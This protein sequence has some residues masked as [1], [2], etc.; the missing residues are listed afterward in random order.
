MTFSDQVR[1][2][3]REKESQQ[4]KNFIE[5]VATGDKGLL[6]LEAP[7]GGGKTSFL[8]HN[9]YLF[10]QASVEVI[11]GQGLQMS[12]MTPGYI[13]S[14]L[15]K[16][17]MNPQ[18]WSQSMREHIQYYFED[19]I[20][21]FPHISLSRQQQYSKIQSTDTSFNLFALSRIA[22][23]LAKFFTLTAS[24]EKPKILILDDVQWADELSKQTLKTWLETEQKH[25]SFFGII[26]C[27][28]KENIEQLS[29]IKPELIKMKID[30]QPLTQN[31]V[32]EYLQKIDPIF[33]VKQAESL[34]QLTAGN[35]FALQFLTS[36]L[37][38]QKK[39]DLNQPLNSLTATIHDHFHRLSDLQ[40]KILLQIAVF[41]KHLEL[42]TLSQLV[43]L[44]AQDCER[45]LIQPEMSLLISITEDFKKVVSFNHDKIR[46]AL[47]DL[48]KLDDKKNLHQKIATFLEHEKNHDLFKLAYHYSQAQNTEKVL[49]FAELAA[50]EAFKIASYDLAIQNYLLLLEFNKSKSES[51]ALVLAQLG[52]AYLLIGQYNLA[53]K[54]FKEAILCAEHKLT[55]SECLGKL[56]EIEFKQG[57]IQQATGLTEEALSLLQFKVPK[58][59]F[60]LAFFLI[61]EI[62]IQT[63]HSIFNFK[64]NLPP[65]NKT[66]ALSARLFSRLAYCYWFG[67]GAL[68]C[69]WAHI[70]GFNITENYADSLEKAQ[71]YSEH[72]PVMT[73]IPWY[74][75]G[76][77]YAR[78]SL[79]IRE[80][81]NSRWGV[82]QSK[83]FIGTCL[84]ASGQF[85]E[86]EKICLEAYDTLSKE[87]DM[88]EANLAGWHI[89]FSLY[90]QGQLQK[91]IEQAQKIFQI[92]KEINDNQ[93][94]AICIGV[95]GKASNG[96]L[97]EISEIEKIEKLDLTDVHAFVE[98]AT[99]KALYFS[100]FKKF[101]EA[102][103]IMQQA[104]DKVNKQGLRQ[105]YVSTIWPWM[106]TIIRY[107][108][109]QSFLNQKDS[110]KAYNLYYKNICES[111]RKAYFYKN[112]LPHALREKAYYYYYTGKVSKAL[113]ILSKSIEEAR[114]QK[115]NYEF[116]TSA[117]LYNLW[118]KENPQLNMLKIDGVDSH[119]K[120]E[121]PVNKQKNN[122]EFQ[123]LDF[124][125]NEIAQIK[126]SRD[127]LEKL[128]LFA[129]ELFQKQVQIGVVEYFF[130]NATY[131]IIPLLESKPQTFKNLLT[132]F[133]KD[134][135]ENQKKYVVKQNQV[136]FVIYPV[137]QTTTFGY[138]Y[139][140]CKDHD[141]ISH[142][143]STFAIL[144]TLVRLVCLTIE[145]KQQNTQVQLLNEDL[146]LRVKQAL[147]LSE[148]KNSELVEAEK[149]ALKASQ[150]KSEF[151]A[152]MSHEIRTP[153]NGVMGTISLL[154]TTELQ[155][156]QKIYLQALEI[157]SENLYN[158]VNDILD[159]SKIESGHQVIQLGP[160][161]MIDVLKQCY[162][163]Y[164]ATAAKKG[165]EL[166]LN[167]KD[168]HEL[169]VYGDILRI[170]QV[171]SNLITNAI[172]FT[173]HGSVQI[174]VTSSMTATSVS[175]DVEVIDS[176][177]GIESSDFEKLFQKFSQLDGSTK[178][179]V[180]GT[181]LG[182]SICYQLIQLM[183][184]QI[185]V[186]SQKGEGSTF[187]F[188]LS[189]KKLNTE[190]LFDKTN[191][192][193][194]PQKSLENHSQSSSQDGLSSNQT[195]A[196]KNLKV[197]VDE[198]NTINQLIIRKILESL[199]CTVTMTENGEQFLQKI[200]SDSFDVA[201]LDCQMP[202]LDGFEAC[203]FIR[204]NQLKAPPIIALTAYAMDSDRQ[205]C[206]DA[207]MDDYLT[208]PVKVEDLKRTIE[209]W[210]QS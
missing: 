162:E 53:T 45:V 133:S 109:E 75:R 181:G 95:I 196:W 123:S 55:R 58:T 185:G 122:F 124:F 127:G 40:K 8:H 81:L 13:L 169:E 86:S 107:K 68:F 76:L 192:T 97:T 38:E 29:F 183:Q 46:E 189:L 51:R 30:L 171:L 35:P 147:T 89:A 187:W 168:L 91:A 164:K 158:I 134:L 60:L 100:R 119:E 28:R 57:H 67:K 5:K 138:L 132:L 176:G 139:I 32:L 16:Y 188:K 84:Y 157:S 145:Q 110:N 83:G 1:F 98:L 113:V 71:A 182:L 130:N 19:I 199:N 208:K 205:R 66:Q 93:S 9:S 184:G 179:K 146:E 161:L 27:C 77:S 6:L 4:L 104:I 131:E 125:L 140:V 142:L 36:N 90:R 195:L 186:R 105:E 102:L 210:L 54:A 153:L 135:L 52:E 82:G 65:I 59:K 126:N 170:R 143:N 207:G 42:Q 202:V 33:N 116:S 50:A 26:I 15:S 203:Q 156:E 197:L 14:G 72:S 88:W 121:T 144:E 201:F 92:S 99:A 173:D 167:T 11:T 49:V 101:D 128:F 7:S 149:K 3:G 39:E 48:I 73:I 148:K 61:K 23:C 24:V 25:T 114:R 151:L 206:F 106:A 178:K 85:F 115:A 120:N 191:S 43:S 190:V 174:K 78:K 204:A 64:K 2:V 22:L 80:K 177:S 150:A 198:D 69:G 87:G 141:I 137:R 70:K 200:K 172:K 17:L 21:I 12:A 159:L 47:L 166:I 108:I 180:A 118:L 193:L 31:E 111:L 62:L 56:G 10:E 41:G 154:K 63:Q 103:F 136:S 129:S 34:T 175:Y 152:N 74:E 163:V 117:T 165:I 96:E 18:E 94:A 20:R 44:G 112:N 194:Q 155:E 79:L 209:K 160:M 37:T